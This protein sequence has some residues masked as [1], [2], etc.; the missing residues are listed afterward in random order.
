MSLRW[1]LPGLAT[2]RY[3]MSEVFFRAATASSCRTSCRLVL[4]TC[5]GKGPVRQPKPKEGG[6]G[7]RWEGC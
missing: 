5:G 4:L 7:C 1:M 2:F 3:T 6:Q